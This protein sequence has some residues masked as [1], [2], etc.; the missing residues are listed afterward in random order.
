[1]IITITSLQ[2]MVAFSSLQFPTF[3]QIMTRAYELYTL[4]FLA[5]SRRV[6]NSDAIRRKWPGTSAFPNSRRCSRN[7]L[8]PSDRERDA[9][10]R[11]NDKAAQAS[12]HN[13]RRS[14]ARHR[15]R[16][17]QTGCCARGVGYITRRYNAR[18][19]YAAWRSAALNGSSDIRRTVHTRPAVTYVEIRD[20]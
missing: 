10:A 3:S 18:V 15:F 5:P 16:I 17:L 8:A 11:C 6:S 9:T 13:A 19:I 1:M 4:F 12:A 20:L 7:V 2:T 14:T